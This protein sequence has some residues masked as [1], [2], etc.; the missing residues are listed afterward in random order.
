MYHL[1]RH[2]R[3]TRRSRF[4]VV[5]L[6]FHI[7]LVQGVEKYVMKG[8]LSFGY[9]SSDEIQV[10]FGIVVVVNDVGVVA[11]VRPEFVV[12][13][14]VVREIFI[15]LFGDVGGQRYLRGRNEARSR[16]IGYT[17]R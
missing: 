8:L 3:V 7:L 12:E 17:E 11:V 1:V 14:D 5:E 6:N 16:W 10:D 4:R 9:S 2:T 15:F 13:F